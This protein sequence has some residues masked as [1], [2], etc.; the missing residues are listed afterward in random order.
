MTFIKK[1]TEPL[2]NYNDLLLQIIKLVFP[3]FAKPFLNDT[4]NS[5]HNDC[6]CLW[7]AIAHATIR[8]VRKLFQFSRGLGSVKK[9]RLWR[10][11]A[12]SFS[13]DALKVAL[14][15]SRVDVSA[16]GVAGS[17][18]RIV[19]AGCIHKW[20]L[21]Q[22]PAHS[23]P[24]HYCEYLASIHYFES[25]F[26]YSF[27]LASVQTGPFCSFSTKNGKSYSPKLLII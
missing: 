8:C 15:H 21:Q 1:K 27:L 7:I 24:A 26:D 11:P 17:E 13:R 18:T 9:A 10:C 20:I 23:A 6:C 25:L 19:L 12:P 22:L 4:R 5:F 3:R 2:R 14:S 16:V